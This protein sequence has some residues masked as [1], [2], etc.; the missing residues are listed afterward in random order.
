[1]VPP[2][3]ISD[4]QAR[5]TLDLIERASGQLQTEANLCATYQTVEEVTDCL[6]LALSYYATSLSSPKVVLPAQLKPIPKIIVRTARAVRTAPTAQRARQAVEQAVVEIRKQ[7][8]LLQV[9]DDFA[10]ADLGVRG[11]NLIAAS[12]DTVAD[13][14]RQVEL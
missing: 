7:I 1:M 6:G 3:P 14:L 10:A 8:E 9:A 2:P 13:K 12:L 5:D 11:G 4:G